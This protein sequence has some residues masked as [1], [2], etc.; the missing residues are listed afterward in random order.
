MNST[1][2]KKLLKKMNFDTD[3][4]YFRKKIN[5]IEPTCTNLRVIRNKIFI[6]TKMI[7][8]NKKKNKNIE[9]HLSIQRKVL[10]SFYNKFCTNN[11][12]L[13]F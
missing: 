8:Y 11:K 3:L 2:V 5:E 6:L 9:I 7:N 12:K 13:Y 10:V 1:D 4:K